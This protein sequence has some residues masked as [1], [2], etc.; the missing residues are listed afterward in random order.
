M[1][2]FIRRVLFSSF[3]LILMVPSAALEGL[4]S[5]NEGLGMRGMGKSADETSALG[6]GSQL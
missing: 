6:G 1:G 3:D 5:E 2:R 4:D